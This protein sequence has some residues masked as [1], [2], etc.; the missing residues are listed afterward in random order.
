MSTP[1][2]APP[3]V[4]GEAGARLRQGY[5]HA[6]VASACAG[7]VLASLTRVGGVPV[8]LSAAGAVLAAAFA[9]DWRARVALAAAG[10]LLTGWWWGNVRLQ[11][12][13]SSVLASRVGEAS[14]A[15]VVVTGPATRGL[16]ELRVPARLS[17]F[18]TLVAN[19]PVLL[20]LPLGRAPPQGAI[21]ALHARLEQQRPPSNGFDERTWL[22][23]HGVHVVVDGSS[24]RIV[25][26][27]SGLGGYADSVR[28]RLAGSVARGVGGERRAVLEGILLGEDQGLSPALKSAFRA[29]G[30]YH[31]LAV[32]GQNVAFV[33]IGVLML[34]WLLGLPRWLGEIGALAGIGSYVLAVGAQPSVIRAGVA[35]ALA[36]LAWL[37]SRQRDRWHFLLLGALILLAWNPYNLYD[38]GFQLSFA[39]VAAIFVAVPRM[40]RLLEGYPVPRVA[41]DAIAVSLACGVATAPILWFQFGRIPVYSVPANALAAPVVAPLLALAF[42]AALVAPV[43]APAAALVAQ[44]NGWLAAYLAGCARL[45]GGLPGATVSSGRGLAVLVAIV[46]AALLLLRLRGRDR[47]LFAGACAAATVAVVVWHVWPRPA[48]PPPTGLRVSFLDVGQGDSTLLQVPQGAVLVDEGPPEARVAAQLA[49]L[50]VRRLAAIVLTHPQRDHVGGA[51]DVLRKLHVGFVLDP[52][53]PAPS[54]DEDA[55]LDEAGARHVRVVPAVAGEVFD[56]GRLRLR[57][58]WPRD[59]GPPGQDP[60]QHAVVILATYGRTDVLLTADAESDVTLPLRLPPVEALKVAHHGSADSGLPSL[61]DGLRPQVAVVS[62]GAHNDYGHPTASTLAALAAVPG[63][64]TFRTDLD[65]RVVLES[66]G[67]RIEV[68]TER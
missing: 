10:L 7:L 39:A 14:S 68:R 65:G 29:S 67:L 26:R 20:E 28:A 41:A 36:C 32:S 61:L 9:A 2:T 46:A 57:V 8:V 15:V 47:R 31:L 30:L 59:P 51:A 33:A 6:L 43:W 37:S 35:G 24:W 48:P 12:I 52:R 53:I 19:E 11:A 62:V 16:F 66:D 54:H 22:R 25:G 18:G 4:V 64:A 63:L 21:L 1:R 27:R 45:V 58:L 55:A 38:A 56:L 60:N 44:A 49:R 42:A 40:R 3:I 34:A 23:R 17:R 50:G 5:P 13:D